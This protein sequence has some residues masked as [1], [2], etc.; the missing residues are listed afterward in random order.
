[1][2]IVI[3]IGGA[4]GSPSGF[5]RYIEELLRALA[6]LDKANEYL[7]YAAFWSGFP[8]RISQ[9]DLPRQS[10][11]RLALRR[12]PQ[13][14]ALPI[15]ER[16]RWRI[17][18]KW[19]L[20]FQ[21]DLF[22]G[23]G[24]ILPRLARLPSVVTIHHVSDKPDRETW[25]SRFYGAELTRRAC[26]E[27]DKLIAISH[28][29]KSDMLGLYGI[30]P[31]KVEVIW[32]GGPA[33]VF[34]SPA[35]DAS[36]AGLA[37]RKPYILFV[38]A[39]NERKNLSTL[40]R[41]FAELKTRSSIAHSLVLAGWREEAAFRELQGEIDRLKIAGEVRFIDSL[42]HEQLNALYRGADL[43]VYPSLLEGFGLPLLEAM[44]CGV[45]VI[46]ARASV[47]PEIAGDAAL[48]F[49]GKDPHDLAARMAQVLQDA[50]LRRELVTKGFERLRC[51]DW[52]RTAAQT[53]RVYESFL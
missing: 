39:I 47:L 50:E 19:L 14:L 40:I 24:S 12:L 42:S 29:T 22:H 26:L 20:P 51:F 1:M 9:I 43:F 32:E 34:K 33:E 8:D 37:I 15:E 36:L 16:L 30:D 21:P 48:Y 10:N 4:L 25:W 28:Q 2:R 49:E 17:Q 46:A 3:D 6:E 23:A 44:A 38:S 18:E 7:L 52:R 13:K 53:L 11:F 45:P 31:C 41:A 35:S 5:R 27:A